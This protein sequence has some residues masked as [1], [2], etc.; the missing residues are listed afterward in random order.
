MHG[1]GIESSEMYDF[2]RKFA[3]IFD[4]DLGGRARPPSVRERKYL[5][6]AERKPCGNDMVNIAQR[7]LLNK[8]SIKHRHK[9]F[10]QIRSYS[11]RPR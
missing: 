5:I 8:Y 2:F 1:T 10:L 4:H 6:S 11:T 9:R 3:F 7:H